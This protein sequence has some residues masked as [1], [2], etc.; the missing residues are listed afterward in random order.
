M[1]KNANIVL[2]YKMC[3]IHIITEF[4]ISIIKFLHVNI[5]M[6]MSSFYLGWHS[7]VY[8][9]VAEITEVSLQEKGEILKNI[10]LQNIKNMINSTCTL[11]N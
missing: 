9:R 10:I 3:G 11:F 6:S 4:D 8:P 5:F 7:I 1:R 2:K